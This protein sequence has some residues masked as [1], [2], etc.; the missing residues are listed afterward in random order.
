MEVKTAP[1]TYDMKNFC[2]NISHTGNCIVYVP[3]PREKEL[4]KM[5][6]TF[7]RTASYRSV[8]APT[9]TSGFTIFSWPGGARP[10]AGNLLS[11]FG[12]MGSGFRQPAPQSRS[13]AKPFP[14]CGHCERTGR[15]RERAAAS[16]A[17]C[18]DVAAARI[19][20]A[21]RSR[22][23]GGIPPHQRMVLLPPPNRT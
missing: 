20:E 17:K 11:G 15:S 13:R 16:P 9:I 14:V 1:L 21:T 6:I 12:V 22:R 2:Q 10:R 19:A 18:R 5:L 4:R 8:A 3:P 7:Y 23:V